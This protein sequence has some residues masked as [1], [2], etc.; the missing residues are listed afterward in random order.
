MPQDFDLTGD[1]SPLVQI[2]TW[3]LLL[4]GFFSICARLLTKYVIRRSIEWD[5]KLIIGSEI[6]LLF[7]AVCVSIAASQGLGKPFD[8]LTEDSIDRIQKANYASIPLLILSLALTKWS[9]SVFI[10]QLCPHG[11][12]RKLDLGLRVLVGL[13]LASSV[14]T[15][16]FQCALP[17]PWN[18]LQNDRCI[19]RR[20]W[21]IYV[22]AFNILTEVAFVAFYIEIFRQLQVSVLKRASLFAVFST[23]LLVAGAAAAQLFVFVNVYSSPSITRSLL[24]PTLCNQAM[25]CLSIVTAC[26]PY[27]KPFMESI[28]PNVVQVQDTISS[29]EELSGIRSARYIL[30]HPSQ[31]SQNSSRR[32]PSSS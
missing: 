12:H 5:D 31:P 19:D 24:I 29:Q 4:V 26:I 11:I 25:A 10:N 22:A 9:L 15:S 16:L 2:L 13:W 20:A 21:W 28:E 23:R 30:S 17:T 7:Q 14:I 18:F 32:G 8:T 6:I 1:R 27:L 3:F